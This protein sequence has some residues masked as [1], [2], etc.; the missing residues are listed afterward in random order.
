MSDNIVLPDGQ[1]IKCGSLMLMDDRMNFFNCFSKNTN[2]LTQHNEFLSFIKYTKDKKIFFDVGSS[3]GVF[4]LTF[5]KNENCQVYSFDGSLPAYLA[6]N[7][8]IMLNNI[9]NIKHFKMMI[10]DQDQ[11][12]QVAYDKHQSLLGNFGNTST[13]ETMLRLDSFSELFDVVPDCIKIDVEGAEYKVLQGSSYIIKN[14]RPILF[15]EV[16]P[17]FLKNFHNHSI[18]D[19]INFFEKYEY[20]AVDVLGNKI[21]DYKKHLEQETTDSNRTVWLPKETN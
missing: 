3:Y 4:G 20:E 2:D 10:G 16:H 17:K 14:H 8:T 12:V 21:K 6:L 11:Y 5:S 19:V 18:Y 15:M 1:K 7:Q 9:D 13:I